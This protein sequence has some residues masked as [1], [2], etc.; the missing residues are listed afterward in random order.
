MSQAHE[1]RRRGSPGRLGGKRSVKVATRT[2]Y[3]WSAVTAP[4]LNPRL[5]PV[6]TTRL[7]SCILGVS[8]L[9]YAVQVT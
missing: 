7:P 4:S 8:H 3:S 9:F 5:A 6:I 2:P 1:K